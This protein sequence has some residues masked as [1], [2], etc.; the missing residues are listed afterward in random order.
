[1]SRKICGKRMMAGMMAAVMIAGSLAVDVPEAYGAVNGTYPVITETPGEATRIQ[2]L[3]F[4]NQVT[5]ADEGA[6][7]QARELYAYLDSVGKSA[8]VLYGHQNDT[9]HKGGGGFTGSTS[10]DTK[11][12]TGSIAAVWGIDTLSLTGAELGFRREIRTR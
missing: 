1:M 9:H 11:D 6:I 5:L 8:Y 10:S 7:S 3:S 2:R 4:E 12:L